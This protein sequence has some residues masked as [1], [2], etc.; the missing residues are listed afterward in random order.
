MVALMKYVAVVGFAGA[1]LLPAAGSFAQSST[2]LDCHV[3][4][5]VSHC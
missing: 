2:T 5:N 4:S 1:L 3:Y